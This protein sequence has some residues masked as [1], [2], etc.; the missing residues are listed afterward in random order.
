MKEKRNETKKQPKTSK[1]VNSEYL[2][3]GRAVFLE[4]GAQGTNESDRSGGRLTGD[5]DSNAVTLGNDIALSS[6]T[7]GSRGFDEI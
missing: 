1:L 2:T 6:V 3:A 4:S 5:H 7:F